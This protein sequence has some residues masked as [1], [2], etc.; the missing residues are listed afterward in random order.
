[1]EAARVL[2][3]LSQKGKLLRDVW[4]VHLTGEEFPSDG[5][6]SRALTEAILK[7]EK[8]N[9]GK[10]NPE[11]VGLF[12]L[13]MVSHS[14]DR[15]KAIAE[16]RQ[17]DPGFHVF[18]ISPG[19]GRDS[20]K[21]AELAHRVAMK[22]NQSVGANEKEGWNR[23]LKRK[24]GWE[25]ITFKE[26]TPIGKI[27]KPKETLLPQFR[28]EVRTWWHFDSSLFNT[29]GQIFS[30]ARIPT[31]LFME[32]YDINREGYHD[33]KDNLTNIDLDYGS[34]LTR[35]AIESVA[36]AANAK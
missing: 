25:R 30:D 23:T 13:D 21:L 28:A 11:F 33:T 10:N 31:V 3:K 36:Q 26:G 24:A 14:T 2:M 29:D 12:V 8:I 1:M 5:S 16:N 35:I 7:K 27:P 34:A 22:W 18:Q 9:S 17:K 6:G 4:L 32:N 20:S 15:D 19:R